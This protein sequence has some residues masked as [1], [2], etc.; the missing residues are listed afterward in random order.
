VHHICRFVR[1]SIDT[2]L[3]MESVCICCID[4][5]VDRRE[6]SLS[7]DP[8]R[9]SDSADRHIIVVR[10][11]V[12]TRILCRSIRSISQVRKPN[13][14]VLMEVLMC[15]S[16]SSPQKGSGSCGLRVLRTKSDCYRYRRHFIRRISWMLLR[17]VMHQGHYAY[18]LRSVHELQGQ[19]SP[20]L[21]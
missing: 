17:S 12:L 9:K 13:H 11:Y 14:V 10:H 1:C 21:I 5:R 15:L 20:V 7:M 16:I 4:R 8:I 3:I 2:G 18:C 19:C 6:L